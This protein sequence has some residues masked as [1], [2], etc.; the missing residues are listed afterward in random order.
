M[1]TI[2]KDEVVVVELQ[3]PANG[4]QLAKWKRTALYA[5][6][7]VYAPAGAFGNEGMA[8]LCASHDGEDAMRQHGHIYLST[9]W[10][11]QEFPRDADLA[12][13]IDRKVR[14]HVKAEFEEAS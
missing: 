6:G 1:S 7:K 8:F 2:A 12:D 9:A 14:S 10:L 11:K 5:D 3:L 4:R 13:S